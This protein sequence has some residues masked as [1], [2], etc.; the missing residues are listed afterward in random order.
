ML[1]GRSMNGL[2]VLSP[3]MSAYNFITKIPSEGDLLEK[4]ML[5]QAFNVIILLIG[6]STIIDAHHYTITCADEICGN[7]VL[8]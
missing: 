2:Q 8:N 3:F 4:A 6:W 7:I 1:L 5:V